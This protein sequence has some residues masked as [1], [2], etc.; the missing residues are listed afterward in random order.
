MG[1]NSY[2]KNPHIRNGKIAECYLFLLRRK[3][4]IPAKFFG[5]LL[6]CQIGCDIP[7][8][9]FMPHPFGIVINNNARIGNDVVLLHQV[10]LGMANPYYNASDPPGLD[11]ILMEGVFVGAG[12][13][14]LGHVTIGEWSV[15]GANSVV[16]IDVPKHSIVVGYNKILEK[17]APELSSR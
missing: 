11:P 1:K 2:P 15:I 9:L 8:R 3:W 4:T 6:N 10:T 12:A 7:E 16:T 13:K 5:F 14:V 17:R